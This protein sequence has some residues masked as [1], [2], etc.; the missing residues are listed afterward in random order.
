LLKGVNVKLE[1]VILEHE[2]K[3]TVYCIC[4]YCESNTEVELELGVI[5]S[6]GLCFMCGREFSIDLSEL[7][8]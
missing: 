2:L 7:D 6:D 1:C 5:Y 4:P 8:E 3:E